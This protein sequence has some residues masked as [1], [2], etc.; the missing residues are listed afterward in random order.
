VKKFGKLGEAVVQSNME[1]MMQ[2]FEQV[3]EIKRRR[4][5]GGRSLHACA[6]RRCCRFSS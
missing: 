3:K 5:F 2:G 4:A 6:A 1:V